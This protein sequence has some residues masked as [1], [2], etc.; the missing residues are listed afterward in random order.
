[1]TSINVNV[2]VLAI[3]AACYMWHTEAVRCDPSFGPSGG[4]FCVKLT[5]YYDYQWATCRSDSY[6]KS[7]TGFRHQCAHTLYS[8]CLYQCM[9]NQYEKSSGSVYSSCRCDPNSA[10]QNAMHV[11]TPALFAAICYFFMI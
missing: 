10:S 4:R 9:L 11:F 1:M 3:V 7:T 8:Y 2:L 5:G 6:I